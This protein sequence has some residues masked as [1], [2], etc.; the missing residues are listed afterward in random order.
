M[1]PPEDLKK[2]LHYFPERGHSFL[3]CDRCFGQIE[4]QKRKKEYVFI[5]EEW[6][7]M[8]SNTSK[9]F[10]VVNVTQPIV[11]DY[12]TALEA[13]FKKNI[14]NNVGPF[15]ISKYKRFAYAGKDITVSETQ[16]SFITQTFVAIKKNIDPTTFDFLAIRK[17]YLEDI[18][19]NPKKL[20]NINSLR[21]YIPFVYHEWYDKLQPN[22]T[23]TEECTDSSLSE[24]DQ[25]E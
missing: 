25:D 18:P 10:E 7:S 24:S 8:V 4:I 6:L 22:I 16:N 19:L 14:K 5:P 2:I 23:G 1:W 12:K 11:K 9:K 20:E 17:L 21:K 3:P 13:Y 15:K